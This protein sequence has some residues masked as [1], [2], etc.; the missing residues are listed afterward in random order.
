M[1]KIFIWGGISSDIRSEILVLRVNEIS[2]SVVLSTKKVSNL[3]TKWSHDEAHKAFLCTLKKQMLS[4]S[5]AEYESRD[6]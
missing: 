2:C 1:F 3:G 4:C 5:Y 6:K